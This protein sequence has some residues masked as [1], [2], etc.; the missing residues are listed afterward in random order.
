MNYPREPK[1]PTWLIPGTLGGMSAPSSSRDVTA[2]ARQGVT[3]LMS[4]SEYAE[5]I[6]SVALKH[7]MRWL[8]IPVE[9]FRPP[10]PDQILDAVRF[11]KEEI[12]KGGTVVVHCAAG[13]GRTG[14]ILACYLVSQGETPETAI[15]RV[16]AFRPGSVETDEQ[17]KAIRDHYL[18][19]VLLQEEKDS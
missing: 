12:A 6:G 5:S 19:T 4:L 15:K 1:N 16:R 13:L 2:L 17:E 10:D 18:S 8:H 14:T 3:A 9:D 11:I 7:G